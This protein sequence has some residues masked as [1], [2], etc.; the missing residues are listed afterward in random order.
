VNPSAANENVPNE[1]VPKEHGPREGR[2]ERSAVALGVGTPVQRL[3][4]SRERLRAALREMAEPPGA[5]ANGGLSASL[6]AAFAALKSI[7]GAG[8]A[9]AAL[10]AWWAKHPLRVAS[11]ALGQ[12]AAALVGPMAR[13]HPMAAI[14]VSGL[15][16]ALLVRGRPWR[17]LLEPALLAVLL[18]GL[19]PKAVAQPASLSWLAMLVSMAQEQAAKPRRAEDKADAVARPVDTRASDAQALDA[20]AA[21]AAAAPSPAPPPQ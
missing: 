4:H 12:G 6:S 2:N 19:L 13:R 11:T 1:P 5:S 7:P 21:N 14:V 10:S 3:A 16:G 8:V 15:L 20:Q 17:W 9:L 18:P